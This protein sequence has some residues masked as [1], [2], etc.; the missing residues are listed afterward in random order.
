MEAKNSSHCLEKTQDAK[1]KC[2]RTGV[3]KVRSEYRGTVTEREIIGMGLPSITCKLINRRTR[4]E[5][6][7]H[8]EAGPIFSHV[9]DG[10]Y[11]KSERVQFYSP[12]IDYLRTLCLEPS[13]LCPEPYQHLQNLCIHPLPLACPTCWSIGRNRK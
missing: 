12:H 7:K 3:K 9:N 6:S 4:A 10:M 5:A 1:S 11:I 8:P 13:G 2:K